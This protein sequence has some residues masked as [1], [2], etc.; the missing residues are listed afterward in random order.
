MLRATGAPCYRCS[1][2]SLSKPEGQVVAHDRPGD[3]EDLNREIWQRS[4]RSPYDQLRAQLSHRQQRQP[5]ATT[6]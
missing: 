5:Q 6:L 2:P 4:G 1:V 3:E